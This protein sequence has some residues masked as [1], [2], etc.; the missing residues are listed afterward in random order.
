MATI[1]E[2][3]SL[4][5]VIGDVFVCWASFEA[6]S[7]QIFDSLPGGVRSVVFASNQHEYPFGGSFS[8]IR[9]RGSR[10]DVRWIDRDN[11]IAVYDDM[12]DLVGSTS[13]NRLWIDV[14]CFPREFLAILIKVLSRFDE[15][16]HSRVCLFYS[17]ADDYACGAKHDDDKWLVKGVQSVAPI[18]G[19]R[20]VRRPGMDLVLLGMLG[21]DVDRFLL[22]SNEIQADRFLLGVGGTLVAERSWMEAKNARAVSSLQSFLDYDGEFR[23]SCDDVGQCMADVEGAIARVS[24]SAD[25][26]IVNLNNK[27]SVIATALLGLKFPRLRLC[28][29][30]GIVYNWREYSSANGKVIILP[31]DELMKL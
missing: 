28:H 17:Q 22:I 5:F 21:F 16:V 30:S 18:L 19:F 9:R 31:V 8:G 10:L 12:V 6:R 23:F 24:E 15:Q 4:D 25:V 13:S 26:M 29:S 27:V 7:S 1:V 11:Q 3:S 2:V 14:T 20:G